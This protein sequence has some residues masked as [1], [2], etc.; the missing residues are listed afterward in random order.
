MHVGSRGNVILQGQSGE[1][2][3]QFTTLPLFKKGDKVLLHNQNIIYQCSIFSSS[4]PCNAQAGCTWVNCPDYGD[5]SSCNAVSGCGWD[6]D[7]NSCTGTVN[8]CVGTYDNGFRW[9]AHSLERGLNYVAKTAN[10]TITDID[11]VVDCT[12]NSFTLTLPDATLNNGKQYNLK[13][14]G[15]GTITL[16]T[17]SSQTIDGGASGT[18]TLTAGQAKILMSNNSNWIIISVT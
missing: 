7:T 3:F 17:T 18:V 2:I 13:N 16:N 14:T 4:S 10:Y 6:S 12:A 15:A 8:T 11:D 9:Y 1:P 5:E